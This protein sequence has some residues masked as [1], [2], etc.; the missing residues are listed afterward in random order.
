M[1]TVGLNGIRPCRP[2]GTGALGWHSCAPA[3]RA[4]AASLAFRQLETK[5]QIQLQSLLGLQAAVCRCREV[6]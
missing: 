3:L 1:Q 4:Q 6:N 2:A 5:M